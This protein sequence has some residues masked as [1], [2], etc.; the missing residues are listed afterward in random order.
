MRRPY[1]L[2]SRKNGRSYSAPT[3]ASI[4]VF[5]QP[6]ELVETISGVHRLI[7]NESERPDEN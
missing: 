4:R 1:F 3:K 6:P 5:P 7:L 2:D